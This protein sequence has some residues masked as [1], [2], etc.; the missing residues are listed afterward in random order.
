M[1]IKRHVLTSKAVFI[2]DEFFEF[3]Y[4]M[5][6]SSNISNLQ[7]YEDLKVLENQI[8]MLYYKSYADLNSLYD[9]IKINQF[10]GALLNSL[11]GQ[12][13][14]LEKELHTYLLDMKKINFDPAYILYD[15][16]KQRFLFRY[17]P[18]K[19]HDFSYDVLALFRFIAFE[20]SL[21]DFEQLRDASTFFVLKLKDFKNPK[22]DKNNNN[23][24]NNKKHRR[25]LHVI[26][27]RYRKSQKE[28][29][30]STS[31]YASP[32]NTTQRM[33][34]PLL[35][36]KSNPN[37]SIKVFFDTNIIGREETCNIRIDDE[38]VSRQH[39]QLVHQ[40]NQFKLIDLNS[41]NGTYVNREPIDEKVVVNGDIIQIGNK[42]F[43]F[44]R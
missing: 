37:Q 44:I 11:L 7:A 30:A 5:I 33:T 41:T 6:M 28:Y 24:S 26:F 13:E 16:V 17:L 42:E 31:V 29:D 32:P 1:M 8:N 38:S 9:L 23:N 2:K 35:F 21:I 4:N 43:I 39:A 19:Y 14:N 18:C 36:E 20:T 22:V 40:K 3:D 27:K 12:I 34:Y 10:N 15:E 25:S